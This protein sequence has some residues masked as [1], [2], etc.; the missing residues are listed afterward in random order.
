MT[1]E[2]QAMMR[3]GAATTTALFAAV[4]LHAV[5]SCRD[6]SDATPPPDADAAPEAASADAAARSDAGPEPLDATIGG[7]EAI[8]TNEAKVGRLQVGAA[9]VYYTQVSGPEAILRVSKAAVNATPELFEDH[10][11]AT[12]IVLS[13]PTL[14]A[15]SSARGLVLG[16]DADKLASALMATASAPTA[17]AVDATGVAF[18]ESAGTTGVYVLPLSLGG[19][20]KGIAV[21]AQPSAI[22]MD[23]QSVYAGFGTRIRRLDR[24][25]SSPQV[26]SA[27]V[28]GPI[29]VIT[30]AGDTI[31][32]AVGSVVM[33]LPITFTSTMA[34]AKVHDFGPGA[35]VTAIRATSALVFVATEGAAN[36]GTIY[37]LPKGTGQQAVAVVSRLS[38]AECKLP[39]M[40]IDDKAIYFL[41]NSTAG[42][43]SV[44]R[45]AQ[46]AP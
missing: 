2:R 37:S 12:D 30:V 10:A 21:G 25:S 42:V 24:S 20:P 9:R 1:N 19:A 14:F 11:S 5:S 44:W 23:A 6:F 41:C 33:A 4:L 27:D 45:V 39:D 26:V 17:L 40:D 22:A 38:D 8:V 15:T 32:A 29:G 35:E 18:L 13:G 46:P 36:G 16:L 34:P 7:A 3:A 31:Y 43:G 28:G